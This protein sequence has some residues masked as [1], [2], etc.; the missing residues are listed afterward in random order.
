M[1]KIVEFF[2][3]LLV[4]MLIFAPYMQAASSGGSG[5]GSPP[6]VIDFGGVI[7]AVNSNAQSTEQKLDNTTN[8]LG[9]A[10]GAIPKG[11]FDLLTGSV[12]N[13]LKEFNS[14]LLKMQGG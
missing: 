9:D 8:I 14:S 11:I 3:P 1:R 13:S 7:G 10:I 5:G 4:A 6:I 12:R 2:I